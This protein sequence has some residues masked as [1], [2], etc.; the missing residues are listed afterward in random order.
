MAKAVPTRIALSERGPVCGALL[1]AGLLVLSLPAGAASSEDPNWPC[2]Q[3]KVPEVS[4]GMVWAGPPLE[5]LQD[6]WRRDPEVSALAAKVTERRT[7]IDTAKADI[8]GFAAGLSNDR[9]Q[10]LTLLFAGALDSINRE[11]A[12]IISG[13]GRF[14]RK[15]RQLADR[16]GSLSAELHSLPSEEAVRKAELEEQLLWDTR[17]YE[18]REKSLVYVCEQPVLLEQR[19]F[20]L[21]REIMNHLD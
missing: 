14:T 3:R 5:E 18:D 19:I 1:A 11:R 10:R 15:Q 9:N 6:D 4:A 2:V 21:S 12:S 7:D 17:I 20:A 8:A 16:I 13:I